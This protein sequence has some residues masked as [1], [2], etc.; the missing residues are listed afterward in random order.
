MPLSGAQ[1]VS[2]FPTSSSLEDLTE[3][4]RSNAKLF[5]SALRAAHATV[6]V[7]DTLRSSQRAYLMHF[8]FE[9]AR[10]GLNPATVP[11]MSGVDIQWVHADS[12]GNV[13]LAASKAA[14]QAM[15]NGYG[16]VF[17]PVL[18][19][20]RHPAQ[21]RSRREPLALPHVIFELKKILRVVVLDKAVSVRA[22]PVKNVI[23][24]LL[25]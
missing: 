7:N 12:A 14:A 18:T 22:R 15:V 3:P 5:I 2:Q 6:T 25:E 8:C 1:W 24:V 11:P 13:D 23:R 16:I 9:I 19:S 20:R 17:Q 4:F 21:R 10:Q